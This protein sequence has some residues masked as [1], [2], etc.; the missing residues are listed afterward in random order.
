VFDD[1]IV[2][3][4]GCTCVA[5][6]GGAGDALSLAL[7]GLLLRRRRRPPADVSKAIA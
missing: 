5:P 1:L 2:V 7:G 4:G 3:G 6:S